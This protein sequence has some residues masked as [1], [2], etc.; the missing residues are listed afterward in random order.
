MVNK[1]CGCNHFSQRFNKKI[2]VCG[3]C[4][5]KCRCPR[6]SEVRD[7]SGVGDSGSRD[8]LCWSWEANS[9]PLEFRAASTLNHG[10][11][12]PALS[13]RGGK[14]TTLNYIYFICVHVMCV[15]RPEN[16]VFESQFSLPSGSQGLNSVVWAPLPPELSLWPPPNFLTQNLLLNLQLTDLAR[17]T[18]W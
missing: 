18:G 6:R 17:L 2:C 5:L 13:L 15:C 9:C 8:L 10:A 3:Y 7:P 16:S 1:I 12:P 4:A 14:T 11:S